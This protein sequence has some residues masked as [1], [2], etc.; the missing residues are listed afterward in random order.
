MGGVLSFILIFII[1]LPLILFSSLNPTNKLN[2]LTKGKLNVDL[3]FI[4]ENDLEL[5]YFI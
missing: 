1:I 5:N 2:N 4:Y 3:T